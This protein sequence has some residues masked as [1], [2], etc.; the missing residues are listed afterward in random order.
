VHW[1]LH[2]LGVDD[3]SG[4]WYG[5]WSGFGSDIGELAIAGGL[6]TM[7]RQRNCEVHRCW[8]L[9]RHATAAGHRVC[10]RH[11]PEGHLTAAG[12]R[13]RH[14]LYLGKQPGRG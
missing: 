3:L 2:V 14:H 8:R 9:G 10:R 11:H 12:V 5:F 7:I 1:L 13:E 4:R 6:V